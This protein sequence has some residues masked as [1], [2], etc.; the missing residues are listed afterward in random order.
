MI[1]Q[2]RLTTIFTFVAFVVFADVQSPVPNPFISPVAAQTGWQILDTRPFAGRARGVVG[3]LGV[4]TRNLTRDQ[5]RFLG[6][7][8]MLEIDLQLRKTKPRLVDWLIKQ[9]YWKPGQKLGVDALVVATE[10]SLSRR[11]RQSY[12]AGTIQFRFENFPSAVETQIRNFM[13]R[14]MPVLTEIYGPPITSPPNST[15]TVTIVLDEAISALDGGVYNA[16]ADEIRLPEFVPQR[17]YDWF[18]LLHQ[19]LHAFRGPLMLSFPAWEEGHA[20]AAAMIAAIRLRGQGVPELSRFD[21][22]DPIH[23]DPLWVLPLYDL[24]NQPPLGNPVFLPPSGYQPMAYWRFAMS[25]AAWLK[26][27]AEN[28]QCFR[29]FNE[30]FLALND[31]DSV[32]GDTVALVD[33]MRDIVP[34]VEGMDFYDWYR[35]QY[36]LDTGISVGTKLYAF[37]VPLH[38]G[39]LLILNH[40]RTSSDGNEFPLYGIAQLVYRNDQ[41]DDL[42]AEEG[43]EAEIYDGEGFIAPQFFNIGGPNLI[44]IDIFVNGL[45]LTVPF[46]YMVR[47]EEPEENPIFGGVLNALSGQIQIRFNDL[48]D[49]QPVS[50]NRSVFAVTQGLDIYQLYRL[51]VRHIDEGIEA[52]EY[53]NAAF[54]IYCLIVRARPSVITMELTLPTGIHL[55]TVPLLPTAFDEAEALGISPDELLLARWNPLRAGNFKYEFYPRI[56][57]PMIPGVGYWLKLLRDTTIRVEGTPI[58]VDQPYEIPLYGGFNQVGNP[59]ARDLPVGEILVMFGNEGPVGLAEAERKGWVQ[60][61]IWVWDRVRGYQL[62]QTVRQWQGFWVRALRTSGVR[63][64]FNWSRNRIATGQTRNARVDEL[65]RESPIRWSLRLVVTATNSPADTENLMGVISGSRLPSRIAKPPMVSNSVWSAFVSEDEM[66]AHDFR[67]ERSN[68]RW[69][70]II[71]SDLPD[72]T[73]VNLS[74][75]GLAQVPRSVTILVTDLTT[76][77]QFSLR[78]RSNYTFNARKG[79]VR[80]FLIEA[81]QVPSNPILRIVS[82]QSLRGRGLVANLVLTSPAHVRAE[83]RTLTGRT[84]RILTETFVTKLPSLTVFWDGRDRSGTPLPFGAYLLVVNAQDEIGRKQQAIRTVMFK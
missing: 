40:Y 2:V 57:T 15:R 39:V 10:T 13:S 32:R 36:V 72:N 42:Y 9:G 28:P 16:A 58:P 80:Q 38:M 11:S 51:R 34:Q 64:V 23:G 45:A 48:T 8:R 31:V 83:I 82:V 77:E 76:G 70:F 22:K 79:E 1:K 74:W 78:G 69:R 63:L 61:A 7:Q 3:A 52:V 50:V 62:A 71:K 5:I 27:A 17:G 84:V 54:D 55:F 66:V 21:P 19:I 24:L 53:R 20:R 26:V 46:P 37:T 56:T 47:G 44:F 65:S 73:P 59:F 14:A 49:L 6:R 60:N 75:E 29:Q 35:R 25:A 4:P 33:L 18:N 43:N 41:S 68:M 12:G 30:T 67:I 81:R